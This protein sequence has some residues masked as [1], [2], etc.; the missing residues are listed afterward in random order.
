M[1]VLPASTAGRAC[2]DFRRHPRSRLQSRIVNSVRTPGLAARQPS[3]GRDDSNST[4]DC[5][6]PGLL[7][8]LGWVVSTRNCSMCC[9]NSFSNFF[10]KSK[11]LRI[12]S[13]ISGFSSGK[14]CVYRKPHPTTI[15][16]LAGETPCSSTRI[17]WIEVDRRGRWGG[18]P[19]IIFLQHRNRVAVGDPFNKIKLLEDRTNASTRRPFAMR[20]MLSMDTFR[21]ARS[22]A[23][24]W[25]SAPRLLSHD[26]RE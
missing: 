12:R 15:S 4:C 22:T 5:W 16:V 21:S 24:L 13:C 18:E 14:A 2:S 17:P 19:S 23:V 10:S 1:T 3:V 9:R 25:R 20:A 26:R 8:P 6:N 11:R 7:S